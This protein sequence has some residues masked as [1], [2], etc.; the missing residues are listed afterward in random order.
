MANTKKLLI[1]GSKAFTM[2]TEDWLI[3]SFAGDEVDKIQNPYDYH[4]LV[5]SLLGI[6]DD[7]ARNKVEWNKIRSKLTVPKI[8]HFLKCKGTVIVVGDPRFSVLTEKGMKVPFLWWT[9]FRFEWDNL[10]GDTKYPSEKLAC[11]KEYMQRLHKWEYSLKDVQIHPATSEFTRMYLKEENVRLQKKV[12]FK[13]RLGFALAF[14]VRFQM[15]GKIPGRPDLHDYTGPVVFLPEINA[16]EEETLKIVLRDLC[17][18]EILTPE[19][20]WVKQYVAPGQKSIDEK[21]SIHREAIKKEKK[22]LEKDE[23]KRI[24]V[25]ECLK[26]LYA[27]ETELEPVVWNILEKLGAT[28]ERPKNPG[29]EDGWVSVEIGNA[30][31]LGVLE[32]ESTTKNQFTEK[33]IEQ[34]AKWKDRGTRLRHEKYKGILIGNSCRNKPPNGRPYPFADDWRKTANISEI[35][36]LTTADLYRLY[37]LQCCGKFDANIFWVDVFETDGILNIDKYFPRGKP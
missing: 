6:C 35:C 23:D 33:G 4:T 5:I 28:V 37:E 31:Y 11:L 9:G 16:T 2:S 17:D 25:R 8:W 24:E 18:V 12:F 14:L 15:P 21:I 10:P 7:E 29:K 1:I 30:K 19:P 26:L 20:D 13:N 32:I 36:V 3:D 34:L 22:Y 27:G